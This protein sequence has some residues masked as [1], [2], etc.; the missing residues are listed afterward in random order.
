[1]AAV[2]IYDYLS[3][4][5][6]DYTTT[7]F[8]YDGATQIVPQGVVFEEGG[9]NTIIHMADDDSEQRIAISANTRFYVRMQWNGLTE[10]QAGAIFDFYHSA[11]KAAGEVNSFY[12]TYSA[13]GG[14]E[15]H[16]YTCRFDTPV[17]RIKNM[18][19]NWRIPTIRLRILGYK[20]A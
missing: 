16:T 12:W 18:N 5:T 10:S 1:M 3:A 6:A 15:A 17:T 13:W 14:T 4:L 7:E 20:P 19:A 11:T 9:K 8:A 2:E